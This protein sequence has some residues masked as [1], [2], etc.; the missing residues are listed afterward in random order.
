MHFPAGHHASSMRKDAFKSLNKIASK[1][2]VPAVAVGDFNVNSTEDK[3]EN[4]YC[5]CVANM[6][7]ITCGRMADCLGSTFYFRKE[8]GL[9]LIAYGA[10]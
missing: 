8:P 3:A 10:A 9:I 5:D 7:D 2:T 6:E 4:I 1:T